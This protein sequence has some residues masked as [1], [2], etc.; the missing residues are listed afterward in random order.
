MEGYMGGSVDGYMSGWIGGWMDR[1]TGRWMKV[2]VHAYLHTL[3]RALFQ[4]QHYDLR[5][6]ERILWALKARFGKEIL[7]GACRNCSAG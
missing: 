1:W 6:T 4:E 7:S 2:W 5:G 3:E